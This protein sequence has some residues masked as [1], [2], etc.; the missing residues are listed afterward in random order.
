M[1]AQA[2]RP[3]DRCVCRAVAGLVTEERRPARIVIPLVP[4]SCES[5]RLGV[6]EP[7]GLPS[8]SYFLV[9]TLTVSD[10][11]AYPDG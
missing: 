11:Q 5:L 8:A 2:L 6:G 4:V 9:K 10:C 7:C 3:L 1:D